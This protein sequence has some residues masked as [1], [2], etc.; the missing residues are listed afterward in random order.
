MGATFEIEGS[1]FEGLAD[2]LSAWGD[3]VVAAADA[4]V[5]EAASDAAT[6]AREA[7]PVDTGALQRSITSEHV[8]WGLALVEAGEGIPY[9]RT[10]EKRSGFFNRSVD[11][12]QQELR[13]R[14][15]GAIV[16]AVF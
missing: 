2:R 12:V 15:S 3:D 14:V 13:E 8:S 9:T 1:G 10:I 5:V 11:T 4:A 7:V 6:L 16:R